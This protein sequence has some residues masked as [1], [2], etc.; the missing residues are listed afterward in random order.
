VSFSYK[1][2][3]GGDVALLSGGAEKVLGAQKETT[4][5][6]QSM[7]GEYGGAAV[8]HQPLSKL[9]ACPWLSTV[10]H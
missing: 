9:D 8:A 7:T 10:P 4:R 5:R 3:G 2:V 6:A 1:P